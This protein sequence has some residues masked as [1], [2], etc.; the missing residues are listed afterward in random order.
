MVPSE[1]SSYT[2]KELCNV[3]FG[4]PVSG[5]R[6]VRIANSGG[7]RRAA[8]RRE[9]GRRNGPADGLSIRFKRIEAGGHQSS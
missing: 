9:A 8:A 4:G 5:L 1:N 2:Q 7:R 3:V 6:A